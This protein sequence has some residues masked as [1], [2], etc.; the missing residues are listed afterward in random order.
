MQ[1]FFGDRLLSAAVSDASSADGMGGMSGKRKRRRLS[2]TTQVITS[3]R[4]ISAAS[5][6]QHQAGE[7]PDLKKPVRQHLFTIYCMLSG[8]TTVYP[9]LSFCTPLS[10]IGVYEIRT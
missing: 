10:C 1:A 6:D 4:M 8:S 5:T 3:N 9:S 2:S 7:A